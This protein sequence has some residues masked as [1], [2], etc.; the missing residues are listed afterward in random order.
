M[1]QCGAGISIFDRCAVQLG[2]A[3]K[4]LRA[5]HHTS[6]HRIHNCSAICILRSRANLP[7]ACDVL[8]DNP[9]FINTC[10]NNNNNANTLVTFLVLQTPPSTNR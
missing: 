8:A 1:V 3:S 5:I 2:V 6:V 7:S 4:E 10:Q 9:N